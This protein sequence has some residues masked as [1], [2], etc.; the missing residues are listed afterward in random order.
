MTNAPGRSTASTRRYLHGVAELLLA[1]P[2]YERSG[3][4]RLQATPGGFGTTRLPELSV[5]GDRLLGPD[6]DVGLSGRTSVQ[7]A[8][9]VGV[10]ARA[11]SELYADGS[12]MSAD[13][14]LS[15]DADAA[16]FL[17]DVFALGN[18]ALL[19]FA[20]QETP[21]LWPEHFDIAV[22]VDE[23]NYGVSPGDGWSS[24]AYA[25]VGPWSVPAG[26]FWDAPFGATRAVTEETTVE[27]LVTFF[28]EGRNSVQSHPSASS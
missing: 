11:P 20:P 24:G 3:T 9:V 13:E 18:E 21:A 4:I 26:D 12:G 22:S 2:Q 23:V 25:Y 6:G 7:V 15:V 10:T 5:R 17:A 14:L 1:G 19:A 8:A 27:Q 16:A 28:R